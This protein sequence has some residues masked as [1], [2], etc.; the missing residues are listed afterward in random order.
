MSVMTTALSGVA[1]VAATGL[2]ALGLFQLLASRLSGDARRIDL[3]A[4]L[5]E[6]VRARI[7]KSE[8]TT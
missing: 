3:H 8:W 7:K 6:P 5:P 2:S 1:F 4:A